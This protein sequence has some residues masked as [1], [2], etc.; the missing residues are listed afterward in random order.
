[1]KQDQRTPIP[2]PAART[3]LNYKISRFLEALNKMKAY[4]KSK[5]DLD[6]LLANPD[7]YALGQVEK[8]NPKLAELCLPLEKASSLVDFPLRTYRGHI[9]ALSP[10]LD[11]ELLSLVKYDTEEGFFI[12]T[13]AKVTYLDQK[14]VY[15]LSER[16]YDLYQVAAK[17]SDHLNQASNDL[18]FLGVKGI[19]VAHFVKS[20]NGKASVDVLK[21]KLLRR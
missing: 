7:M 8:A 20:I 17:Y 14:A 3:E 5:A 18:S 12:P 19:S 4:C 6:R 21:I 10:L 13:K 9:E 15:H 2:A 16:Q 11:A 1:M